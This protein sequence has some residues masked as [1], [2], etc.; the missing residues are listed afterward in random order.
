M[1]LTFSTT[2]RTAII[3]GIEQSVTGGD[4]GVAPRLTIYGGTVTPA[5]TGTPTV[6]TDLVTITFSGADWLSVSN[7]AATKLGTWSATA[8]RTGVPLYFRITNNA[9]VTFIQG[10]IA[11]LGISGEI[12][13]GATVSVSTFVLTAGNA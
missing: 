7:G 13:S 12:A 3:S 8:N 9:G 6:N 11:D 10:P 2:L 4:P 1:A 5:I